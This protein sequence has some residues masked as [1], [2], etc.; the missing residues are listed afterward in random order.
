M[1]ALS[2]QPF[3]PAGRLSGM[4]TGQDHRGWSIIM[5]IHHI[6]VTSRSSTH[7]IYNS[8][9]T[10]VQILRTLEVYLDSGGGSE[11]NNQKSCS[12]ELSSISWKIGSN[13]I[14]TFYLLLCWSRSLF[15]TRDVW[16]GLICCK[17][18]IFANDWA[19][20]FSITSHFEESRW[21][22]HVTVNDI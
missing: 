2:M 10:I 20:R 12:K 22:H 17:I 7:W 6:A 15:V 14:H 11:S 3:S 4:F 16:S 13:T 5:K 9:Q 18:T 19:V 21:I 1:A 8:N